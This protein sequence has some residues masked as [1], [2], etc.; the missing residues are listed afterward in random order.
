MEKEAKFS[1]LI[2]PADLSNYLFYHTYSRVSGF[3]GIFISLAA[4]VILA[5]NYQNNDPLKNIFLIVCGA[6]F[7]VIQPIQLKMQAAK[8]VKLNPTYKSPFEYILNQDGLKVKQN[9][10][11][12]V[13]PWD[14]ILVV[15]E[16]SKAIFVYTSPVAAFIGPK[17]QFEGEYDLVKEILKENLKDAQCK[18][19]K[20]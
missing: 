4:L 8:L 13:V 3:I 2:K 1:I 9:D 5:T 12:V 20:A 16:T 17:A 10:E 18:W 19:K 7:T 11:E 15:K 6:L 14:G